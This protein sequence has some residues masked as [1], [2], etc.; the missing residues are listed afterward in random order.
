MN[1]TNFEHAGYAIVFQ[2]IIWAI[3]KDIM[4]GSMAGAFFFIGREHAQ[5]ERRAGSEFK[6]FK[7]EYWSLDSVL[8]IIFP[9]VAVAAVTTAVKLFL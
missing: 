9:V 8:D 3:S 5:A 2:L 1:K 4:A 6:A 7:P